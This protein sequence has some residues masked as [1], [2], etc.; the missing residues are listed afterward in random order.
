M[1]TTGFD[2]IAT[3]LAETGTRRGALRFL[4]AALGGAGLMVLGSGEE[5]AA[6]D[7]RKRRRGSPLGPLDRRVTRTYRANVDCSGYILR[8]DPQYCQRSHQV[9]FDEPMR[10]E[11]VEVIAGRNHCSDVRFDVVW[12]EGE[13][14]YYGSGFLGAGQSTGPIRPSAIGVG[15]TWSGGGISIN[16]VSQISVSA[17]GRSGGCN[18]GQLL[19]W[20]ATIKVTFLVRQGT[21]LAR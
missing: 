11:S 8:E 4:A 5:A 2:R 16:P 19:G 14:D 21:D 6:K 3:T 18:D 7:K 12:G 9:R 13:A 1:D 20:Q 17:E 15:D 10:V